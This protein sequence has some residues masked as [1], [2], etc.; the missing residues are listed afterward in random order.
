MEA[1]EDL[2]IKKTKRK[3]FQ[4]LLLLLEND[5]YDDITV[6]ELCSKADIRRATFYKHFSDKNAFLVFAIHHIR[7]IFDEEIWKNNSA[8]YG[9]D[10]FTAYASWVVDYLDTHDTVINN[11]F[12]S[13][14]S[15]ELFNY[16]VEVNKNDTIEHLKKRKVVGVEHL[17][18][19]AFM[20]TGGTCSLLCAWLKNGKLLSKDAIK[21]NLSSCIQ[22]IL[23]E[24]NAYD[25]Y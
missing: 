18:I 25:G 21:E 13:A 9:A 5:F 7:E 22:A 4:T 24:N 12:R 3:L 6:N 11:I 23:N 20:I 8:D 10:Y 14:S 17:E 16:I 15:G 1:K 2:R 19:I